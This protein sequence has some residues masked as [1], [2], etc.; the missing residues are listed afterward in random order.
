M[1]L[2]AC[3][4]FGAYSQN[5][6]SSIVSENE[7]EEIL[8]PFEEYR[9][10]PGIE[11]RE[12]WENLP[13]VVSRQILSKAEELID[14]EWPAISATTTLLFVRTG[15]RDEYQGLSFQKRQNLGT[16]LMAELIENQGRFLD[17]VMNGIWSIC[18]ESYWGVPAHLKHSVAGSG[19]PDVAEPWVDLFAAET[20]SFLAWT[21]YFLGDKLDEISPLIRKRIK[22]EV[23]H[24]ILN[25]ILER[26]H[27]WR[28]WTFNWNPW[29]T[30]NWLNTVLL[31]EENPD[32]RV[33]HVSMILDAL[34]NFLDPYPS[35]GGCDE[36]PGYWNAAGSSLFESLELL[37]LAT[38]GRYSVYDQAKIRNIG[39]YIYKVQVSQN[40]FVNFADA[41][42]ELNPAGYW[43]YR[44]G[45]R[46]QD[47][48]M[49]DFASNYLDWD[50][51]SGGR[52][53]L[54][55]Q[56]LLLADKELP[57]ASEKSLPLPGDVWFPQI[58][59][60]LSRDLSGT[61]QGLCLAAKG[62]NNQE[63]HNHNDVGSYMV[64]YNGEPV[65]IDVGRGTY[66]ARF[67]GPERYTMWMCNSAHH[68][69]PLI[70]GQQQP[71]GIQFKA[72]DVQ[73][74]TQAKKTILSMEL[75]EAYPG[76]AGITAWKRSITHVKGK[77]VELEEAFT[78]KEPGTISEVLMTTHLPD[79]STPGKISL[80]LSEEGSEDQIFHIQYDKSVLEASFTKM[81]MDQP[82]DKA[83]IKFW[84]EDVYRI[85]LDSRD[86]MKDGKLKLEFEV[87]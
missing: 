69:L 2:V 24:R 86:N 1:A 33:K 18:E 60:M 17:Q 77:K 11:A 84:G 32:L 61:D 8:L 76:E 23:D 6:L 50:E 65:I 22:E 25:A 4:N 20:A 38:G 26:P 40:S 27:D 71:A 81:K 56:F 54:T 21:S 85:Q 72:K 46:I 47:P 52:Y 39:S 43:I 19:L 5:L 34:D 30:S 45:K 80:R 64:Y 49:M 41:D 35:D 87:R 53:H 55:R 44:F 12:T 10:V 75:K 51:L 15:D 58:E 67:F 74:S 13:T 63:A 42:P 59:W 31:L 70:N 66:T 37:N 78:L 62:G 14:Y 79:L 48:M 28:E 83:V 7:L 73:Y 57:A 29:I 9:P 3:I 82:E 68:N 16:L 36:G